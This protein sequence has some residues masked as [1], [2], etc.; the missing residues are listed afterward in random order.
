M[1]E[2]KEKQQSTVSLEQLFELKRAER[3]T[4]EFWD[5]F[6]R[7]LRRRQLASFV[8]VRPWYER[9][10]I[11]A[12]VVLKRVAP[13]GV[14][15]AALAAGI[16]SV[17]RSNEAADRAIYSASSSDEPTFVLLPEERVASGGAR[18]QDK[19]R[20]DALWQNQAP[21]SAPS[22]L[23][24]AVKELEI[25]HNQVRSFVTMSSPVT[26]SAPREDSDVYLVKS[27]T[28]TPALAPA[29]TAEATSF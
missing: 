28:S 17:N 2:V 8:S 5:E 14:A 24:Y 11:F 9:F 27:L 1:P 10:G 26:L 6:D 3:P 20:F 12:T 7:E 16:V 18:S 13:V 29:S 15:A 19:A 23:Q 22:G 21:V 4:T 25:S